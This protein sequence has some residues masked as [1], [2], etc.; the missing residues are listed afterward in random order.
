MENIDDIIDEKPKCQ[1]AY[2]KCTKD[3]QKNDVC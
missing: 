2:K 1:N 3:K